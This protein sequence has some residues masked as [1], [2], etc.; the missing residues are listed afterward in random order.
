M[1]C[2]RSPRRLVKVSSLAPE[3]FAAGRAVTIPRWQSG[4]HTVLA[5]YK[6]LFLSLTE[7]LCEAQHSMGYGFSSAAYDCKVLHCFC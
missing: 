4:I 5:S 1:H 7:R 6:L 3:L 2:A